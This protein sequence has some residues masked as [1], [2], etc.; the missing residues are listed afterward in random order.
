MAGTSPLCPILRRIRVG[1][2][3]IA[4]AANNVTTCRKTKI[5]TAQAPSESSAGGQARHCRAS[6]AANSGVSLPRG[7]GHRASAKQVE[8]EMKHALPRL[9]SDIAQDP[10]AL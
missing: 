3:E 2:I 4:T 10:V 5:R 7:P 6:P 1:P 8:V 9:R